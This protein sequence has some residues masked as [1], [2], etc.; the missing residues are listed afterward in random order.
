M[1]KPTDQLITNGRRKVKPERDVTHSHGREFTCYRDA[2]L[3][4]RDPERSSSEEE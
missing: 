2:Y 3:L 4:R 1:T